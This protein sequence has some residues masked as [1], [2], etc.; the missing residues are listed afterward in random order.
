MPPAGASRTFNVQTGDGCSWTATSN[1]P[2]ITISQ[3]GSGSGNGTVR[4]DVAANS[5]AP[6]T[7]T[8]TVGGVAFTVQQESG[9]SYS[10]SANSTNVP[11]GG[12]SGSVDVQTTA[13][14]GWTASSGVALV[15]DYRRRKRHGERHREFHGGG[16][17]RARTERDA[18]HCRPDIYRQ[19]GGRLHVRDFAAAT[20][21][22]RRGRI[23][24]CRRDDR[25]RLHVDRRQQCQLDF[26]HAGCE[27]DWQRHCRPVGRV[28]C[29]PRTKR[30]GHDCGELTF[31]VQQAN[32]CTFTLSPTSRSHN[33]NG[34]DNS[35]DVSTNVGCPWKAV[36]DVPWITIEDGLRHGQRKVDYDV[37]R[38]NGP[39][40]KGTITVG[41]AVFTVMQ[42]GS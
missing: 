37:D 25:R 20:A 30:N 31:T 33:A 13:G 32:G 28:D 41:T 11:L 1:A 24:E 14:C 35:F 38:N 15:D 39:A 6:R 29:R 22:R 21:C 3:G 2:W 27:R 19:P 10:L 18:H 12:G 34:G 40:R 4:I 17:Y 7:G 16:Q 26:S 42:S 9:C 23:G 36:S 5:G 8:V